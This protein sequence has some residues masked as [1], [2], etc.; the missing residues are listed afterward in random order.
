MWNA[1]VPFFSGHTLYEA[2]IPQQSQRDMS[3]KVEDHPL[4]RDGSTR[5]P[6]QEGWV[7]LLLGPE[8]TRKPRHFWFSQAGSQLLSG[9]KITF[10]LSPVLVLFW[11]L[12][13]GGSRRM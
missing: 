3:C 1:A 6:T 7:L 8:D 13:A 11:Y 4:L 12:F 5:R 2:E 9:Q 10:G